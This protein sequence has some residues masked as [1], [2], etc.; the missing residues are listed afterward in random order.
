VIPAIIFGLY[1]AFVT[2]TVILEGKTGRE[3][4]RASKAIV[5]G[6]WWET[7]GMSIVI[8]LILFVVASVVLIPVFILMLVLS[9]IPVVFYALGGITD[10]V[11]AI[12]STMAVTAVY[13][14]L[15]SAQPAMSVAA[16]TKEQTAR[17]DQAMA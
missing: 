13:Y 9:D 5:Y 10:A 14:K 12:V 4:L 2:Q 1:W 7:L 6:R 16:E 17:D 8:P 3:A 11:Y 15:K